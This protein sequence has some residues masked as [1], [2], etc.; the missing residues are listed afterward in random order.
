MKGNLKMNNRTIMCDRERIKMRTIEA[1]RFIQ[2]ATAI[3]KGKPDEKQLDEDFEYTSLLTDF[4]TRTQKLQDDLFLINRKINDI[5]DFLISDEDINPPDDISDNYSFGGRFTRDYPKT[6]ENCKNEYGVEDILIAQG[7][8]TK[9]QMDSEHSGTYIYFD[10][11]E[12]AS[13]FVQKFNE[14]ILLKK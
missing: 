5:D 3:L 10:T 14:Y 11:K 1:F 6:F 2:E 9:K 12:E 13:L 4:A 7:I 8:T